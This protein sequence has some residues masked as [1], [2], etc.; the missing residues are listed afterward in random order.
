M[1][2]TPSQQRLSA[3]TGESLLAGAFAEAVVLAAPIKIL[4]R[5]KFHGVSATAIS[6]VGCVATTAA[7]NRRCG[8]VRLVV[9]RV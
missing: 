6:L 4:E 1:L 9:A 7:S 8:A 5:I 2:T 3:R